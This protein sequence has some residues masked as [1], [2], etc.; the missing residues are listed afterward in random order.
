MVVTPPTTRLRASIHGRKENASRRA[1]R[2]FAYL[3]AEPSC[4]SRTAA[5]SPQQALPEVVCRP[6]AAPKSCKPRDQ[7]RPLQRLEEK[8][9]RRAAAIKVPAPPPCGNTCSSARVRPTPLR[10]ALPK[11]ERYRH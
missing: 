2:S 9:S 5:S 11:R 6:D 10:H 4:L 8:S 3:K 7:V 1:P